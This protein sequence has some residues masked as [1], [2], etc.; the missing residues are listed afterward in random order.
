MLSALGGNSHKKGTK[1]KVTKIAPMRELFS[2]MCQVWLKQ[3][4]DHLFGGLGLN[5]DSKSN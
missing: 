5:E 3:I 1:S 4:S 2:N